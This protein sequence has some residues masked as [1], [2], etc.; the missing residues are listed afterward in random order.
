MKSNFEM[1][2][3]F[4]LEISKFVD[5]VGGKCSA[6]NRS[7]TLQL[8]IRFLNNVPHKDTKILFQ[9]NQNKSIRV[10]THYNALK[11]KCIK[12]HQ[13]HVKTHQNMSKSRKLGFSSHDPH[14]DEKPF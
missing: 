2:F 12:A 7:S 1:I 9:N 11:C 8:G 13:K 4:F 3:V 14:K 6:S 5:Q 10:K